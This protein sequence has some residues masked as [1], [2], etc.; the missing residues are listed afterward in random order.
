M[1]VEYIL[2]FV[3]F[4]IGSFGLSN[5]YLYLIKQ[6]NLFS[7]MNKY[8][9]YFK[10]KNEFIFRSIGGCS[11]CTTQRF[12]DL[13][14]IFLSSIYFDEINKF[15]LLPLY[16]LYGGFTFWL[17]GLNQPKEEKHEIVTEKHSFKK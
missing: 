13:S 4:C 6:G 2:T 15:Y 1:S 9:L 14:F 5:L 3:V 7:F 17:F 8:L 12:A 11:I 10:N 16:C